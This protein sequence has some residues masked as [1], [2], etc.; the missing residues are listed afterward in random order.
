MTESKSFF[1]KYGPPALGR[2]LWGKG[3][4]PAKYKLLFFGQALLFSVA[5]WIRQLDVQKAQ[6]R[7]KLLDEMERQKAAEG[8]ADNAGLLESKDESPP[9]ER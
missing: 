6:F 4:M 2:G 9:A 7:K 5:A 8:G 1:Q 3:P